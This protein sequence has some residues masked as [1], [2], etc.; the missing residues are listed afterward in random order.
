MCA[1]IYGRGWTFHK[2]ISR[3]TLEP[4]RDVDGKE[5]YPDIENPVNVG[6]TLVPTPYKINFV[7]RTNSLV[8]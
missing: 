5:Q 2:V 6:L 1:D 7:E 3:C 8:K 4:V